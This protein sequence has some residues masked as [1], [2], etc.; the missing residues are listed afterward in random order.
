MDRIRNLLDSPRGRLYAGAA[1]LGV[2][3]LV[4]A[5]LVLGR[6][7]PGPNPSATA[8]STAIPSSAPA[9]AHVLP[10]PATTD[11]VLLVG[12]PEALSTLERSWL[13]DLRARFGRAD[14]LAYSAT[15]LEALQRYFTVFVV[16]ASPDLDPSF[17]RQAF[18]SGMTVHL[19][20][21]A[22]TYR[23]SVVAVTGP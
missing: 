6:P 21:A 4:G 20:G 17:L 22:T 12:S 18:Q 10:T 2:V 11:V 19:I 8:G 13:D 23:A 5:A 16:D 15:T 3:V 1:G 14:V 9:V 7:A